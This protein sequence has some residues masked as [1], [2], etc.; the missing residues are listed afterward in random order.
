MTAD[1][2]QAA[3][4]ATFSHAPDEGQLADFVA[5]F[6]G[7]PYGFVVGCYP[8]GE[9]GPLEKYQGPDAWQREVLEEIGRE[10][11]ARGFDGEDAVQAIREAV[12]SGHGIGKSTLVA[13]LID[14]MMSTR[15]YAKGTVTANTVTQLETKT[16]P[17]IRHWT[18]LCVT[19]HW[20]DIGT[21]YL[22]HKLH[23][24]KWFCEAQTC[25]EENS[26]AFQGQHNIGSTS[27]Y[28][29]DEAS[30]IPDKIWE[31][32][33]GGLTDGEPMIFAFGNPTRNTGKFFR[34]CFGSDQERWLHRSID[35]RLCKIPNKKQIDEWLQDY[36]ED[37]DFFRVRVRGL[38]PAAGELQF[39]D[40]TRIREAMARQV[41]VLDN[42]P[43]IAGFDV[44]GGGAAW[45]VIRF[46][47]GLDGCSRPPIRI[48]GEKGRD[49]NVLVGV[50]A[51]VLSDQR[52][53]RKVAMMFVDS[54]FGAAIV[55]RLRTLGH[56]NVQEV[57]FGAESP[58]PHQA[59]FRAFM[60]NKTK[61]WLQHGA[62]PKEEKLETDLNGPGY[63]INRSNKLVIESKAEMI[64]RG[65][66]SPDDGDALVLT[67]ARP[68]APVA[69]RR[70]ERRSAPMSPWT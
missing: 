40:T 60:W 15:P 64:K 1:R 50:A 46:R 26:E 20:F 21:G 33:E 41:E 5:Q 65:V 17:E 36:G 9:P 2:Y 58:D 11:R 24:K 12:A 61:D 68:V 70:Q 3:H 47:R 57:S 19:G 66:A 30:A 23:P 69:Q 53:D 43:L 39:I 22:R 55:E 42:E 7:D 34:V 8:W 10:V 67:F 4:A 62:L 27:F 29:F 52:P 13:W 6:Y 31:V 37:S 59:N 16:W 18:E 51:E 35:S 25:K 44:S 56:R 48:P 54:A 28:V 49:R 32:A 45:N 38:P 63:H 14:W